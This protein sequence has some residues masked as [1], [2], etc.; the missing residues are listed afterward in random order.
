MTILFN[1]VEVTRVK[2]YKGTD[3]N[4][5]LLRS[6]DNWGVDN[7]LTM[8]PHFGYSEQTARDVYKKMYTSYGKATE[9]YSRSIKNPQV[10]DKTY[11]KTDLPKTVITFKDSSG[12][13]SPIS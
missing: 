1:V 6:G 13:Y 5:R 3:V 2:G 4:I 9:F 8:N 11:P 7:D 12:V 10:K